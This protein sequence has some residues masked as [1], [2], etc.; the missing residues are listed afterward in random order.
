MA[1]SMDKGNCR[2]QAFTL[3][4]IRCNGRVRGMSPMKGVKKERAPASVLPV[5]I[6]ALALALSRGFRGKCPSPAGFLRW[7]VQ[8][9]Q[10]FVG[11]PPGE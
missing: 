10:V 5:W 3:R 6:N 11:A 1:R 4:I 9:K 2:N 7:N 8:S